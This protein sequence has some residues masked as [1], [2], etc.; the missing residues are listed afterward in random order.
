MNRLD[1]RLKEI[2]AAHQVIGLSAAIVQGKDISWHG[3]YGWADIERR[4]PV[5]SDTVFRAESIS[6]TITATALMQ[7][8]EQGRCDLD[9]EVG[10]YL[11]YRLRH[12]L[13]PA[14]PVTLRQLMTHTSSIQDVYVDFAVASRS[15]N[16]PRLDLRELLLPGGRYY[17]DEMWGAY[18]PENNGQ[19]EYSNLG[20]IILA[21]IIEKLSGQRFDLYCRQ[22]I[23]T[24]L[25]MTDTSFNLQDYPQMD[26]IAVLYE[27]DEAN[28]TFRASMD[29]YQ[30]MKPAGVEYSRYIPGTNGAIF[31]PQGGVRTHAVDLSRFMLAHLHGGA[32][33]DARILQQ[34]TCEYMHAVQ[35]SGYSSDRFF[36]KSGLNFHI[37]EDLVPNRVLIG[38]AGDAYGLLSGMYFDKKAGR[39]VVYL[40]NGLIQRKDNVFFMAEEQIAR[41]L[42]E[43]K[44]IK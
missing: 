5:R 39:G 12:P 38:H 24:P 41:A 6:K 35:W 17:T 28:E 4:I 7:L 16:P 10:D 34:D 37:T 15:E 8:V 21:T 11:G 20:A 32:W 33:D 31:G 43:E 22:H 19:F 18:P 26:Q 9:G 3:S 13:Y 27:Y 30:G 42:I 2:M 14:H 23:F 36:C 25:G 1:A 44:E 40:M 29:N